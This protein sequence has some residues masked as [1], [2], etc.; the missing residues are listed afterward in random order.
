MLQQSPSIF[1]FYCLVCRKDVSVLTHDPHEILRHFHQTL[2]PQST[3]E[4]GH[5]GLG[6]ARIWRRPPEPCRTKTATRPHYE[7]PFGCARQGVPFLRGRDCGWV[8]R[9]KFQSF[10]HGKSVLSDSGFA[11]G[12]EL[13]AGVWA[14]GVVQFVC[15]ANEHRCDVL[16]CRCFVW[17]FTWIVLRTY[18][19]VCIH[20]WRV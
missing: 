14:L 11:A 9:R 8:W 18:H 3:F 13:R 2:S 12:R 7:S 1:H 20:L 16:T 4:I 19:D 15:W 6:S 5:A 10:G 17:C